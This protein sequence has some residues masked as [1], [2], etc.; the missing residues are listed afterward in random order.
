MK[1]FIVLMALVITTAI[2]SQDYSRKNRASI[3]MYAERMLGSKIV[4][5]K[6]DLAIRQGILYYYKTLDIPGKYVHVSGGYSGDF[7]FAMWKMTNG[8]D[9][10]G[11]TNDNCQPIC[12]YACSMYEFTEHDSVD[13]SATIFPINKMEKHL[14]KLKKKVLAENSDIT[15]DAAQY[16][17]E[18]PLDGDPMIVYLTMNHNKFKTPLLEL[19][20]NGEQFVIQKKYKDL[21]AK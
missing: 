21:S 2:Y 1:I 17:F 10:I 8:N 13:V 15:D 11:I 9:L 7:K 20:W 4:D 18:L 19:E 16:K 6:D 12:K 5:K 14:A 3:H